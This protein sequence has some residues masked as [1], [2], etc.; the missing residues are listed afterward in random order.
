MSEIFSLSFKI[1]SALGM[2]AASKY[3]FRKT[4]I[5]R[6]SSLSSSLIVKVEASRCCP[7]CY[8]TVLW[9]NASSIWKV[10]LLNPA[11]SSARRYLTN[12]AEANNVSLSFI[13]HAPDQGCVKEVNPMR[14]SIRLS[15]VILGL[16]LLASTSCATVS[17]PSGDG[18]QKINWREYLD[19]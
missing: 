3:R 1:Q 10:R 9:R 8:R 5:A 11:C 12:G 17:Y 7:V 2:P 4:I 15:A 13:R 18:A 6:S 16:L 19:C 14:N